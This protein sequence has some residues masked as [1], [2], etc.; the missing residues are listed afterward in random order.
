[1]AAIAKEP[2][3]SLADLQP[4]AARTLGDF[5]KKQHLLNTVYERFF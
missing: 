3:K 4:R 1:V 2:V 5:T